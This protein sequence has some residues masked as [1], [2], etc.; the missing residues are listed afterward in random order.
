M[1][2]KGLSDKKRHA[3]YKDFDPEQLD[4]HDVTLCL[5]CAKR[6]AFDKR[7][8]MGFLLEV[9]LVRAPSFAYSSPIRWFR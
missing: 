9:V 3:P 4:R 8:S 6:I 5:N 7:A 1:S 2:D